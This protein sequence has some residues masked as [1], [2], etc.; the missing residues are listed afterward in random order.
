MKVLPTEFDI[1]LQELLRNEETQLAIYPYLGSRPICLLDLENQSIPKIVSIR[2]WNEFLE[3]IRA[4]H[5]LS[6]AAFSELPYFSDI[7]RAFIA[8]GILQPEGIDVLLRR[9]SEHQS[10][11]ESRTSDKIFI[12]LDT[13]QLIYNTM[14]NFVEQAY[15]RER[16][17]GFQPNI[18]Y[19]VAYWVAW[20][21]NQFL[22]TE[23]NLGVQE[24]RKKFRSS[25]FNLKEKI[26]KKARLGYNIVSE[27]K[28]LEPAVEMLE[29]N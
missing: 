28:A 1:I 11:K 3:E 14:S 21:K 8:S 17:K 7:V 6:D 5:N 19:L 26:D 18:H 16:K 4:T 10:S 22:R 23:N 29:I 25:G 12:A 24:L 20:E 15:S 27:L 9:I 2:E 13:N